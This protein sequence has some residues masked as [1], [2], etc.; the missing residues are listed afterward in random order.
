MAKLVTAYVAD[1]G[2]TLYNQK[3]AALHEDLQH[4]FDDTTVSLVGDINP[5][6]DM[7]V[8]TKRALKTLLDLGISPRSLQRKFRRL[9]VLYQIYGQQVLAEGQQSVEEIPF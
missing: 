2:S 4:L 7:F 6:Y 8:N 1:K 5:T 3:S 9:Y